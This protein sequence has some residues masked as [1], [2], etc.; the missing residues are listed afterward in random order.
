MNISSTSQNDKASSF[1]Q[2]HTEP[3]LLLLPNIWN[4]IGA[5][6]LAGKGYPAIATA[7]AAI[8]ASL[9][10]P[11]GE[12]ISK[13]TMLHELERICDAVTIPVTADIESGYAK[14]LSELDETIHEVLN[15]GAIGIN[16]QDSVEEGGP[17]RNLD[18]QCRRIAQIRATADSLNVHLFINARIDAFVSDQFSSADEIMAVAVRRAQA[19]ADAGA[20]A[21][22]PMGP[23]DRATV[24]Q[25]RGRIQLPLNILAAP[26]AAPLKWLQS[27]GINRVS[28]GPY[29]FR[30]CRQKF[31][32]IADELMELGDYASFGGELMSSSEVGKYLD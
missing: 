13:N 3:K 17:L 31:A 14:S 23:G 8:S 28:F 20:D 12:V 10:Y 18:E 19:Y 26:G 2:L 22:Y 24:K 29:I 4:P 32:N 15:T 1:L 30:S 7:S 27:M 5:R 9:G 16:I 6:I 25:L 11:D 21:V